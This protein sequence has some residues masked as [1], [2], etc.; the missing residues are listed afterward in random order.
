MAAV[1]I[2]FAH[3]LV[4]PDA[5]RAIGAM[6][7]G[8]ADLREFTHRLGY[9]LGREAE[10][11]APVRVGYIEKVEYW[12]A[13]WGTLITAF[14][15]LILWFENLTLSWLPGW[16]PE[17]ATVLHFLEA[18]LATLAILVWHFYSVMFDPVVYPLDTAWLTGKA[19]FS[20]AEE[21]GE[22]SRSELQYDD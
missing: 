7:P 14:T 21:R 15:G 11:P 12:A 13:L 8:A 18:I 10:A 3:L 4:S 17:A 5:R 22:A 9:N 2:H 1:V 19:P 6:I 16:V 20:R